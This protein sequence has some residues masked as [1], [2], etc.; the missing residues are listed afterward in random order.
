MLG[1]LR[2]ENKQKNTN[3]KMP[4][5]VTMSQLLEAG[6]HYGHR[7]QRWNPKMDP[8]IH[9]K[10][11]GVYII[12]LRKTLQ[13]LGE[14]YIYVRELVKRNG[15]ILFVGTKPSITG[16][17]QSYAEKCSMPYVNERWL[18]G[19]LTNFST[20]S[21]QT[22]KL[23]EFQMMKDAGDF[24]QM[25]KKEALLNQREMARLERNLGG[26]RY[27]K[28]V[29]EAV[30]ILDTQKEHIAAT[31]AQKL[32]IPV[33]AVV[34]TNCDPD[35]VDYVIPGNDDSI[36]SGELMCRVIS[37]AVIAGRQEANFAPEVDGLSAIEELE[38]IA[39]AEVTASKV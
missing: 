15:T 12:D 6:V 24:E 30:F 28:S 39:A 11:N 3:I 17:V 16:S 20:I 27:M 7:T 13:S 34:D 18:G 25:P 26:I 10:H 14:V 1:F 8:Y 36:L 5:V 9:G 33:I 21:M 29:P 4:A 35:V 31:E 2:V 38:A 19:T 32:N 37:D 22:A 23:K